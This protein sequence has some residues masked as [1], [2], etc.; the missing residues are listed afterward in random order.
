MSPAFHFD[1]LKELMPLMI[2]KTGE[3][4]DKLPND[5]VFDARP[6]LSKFTIDVLGVQGSKLYECLTNCY[7]PKD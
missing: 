1:F 3:L 2:S 7:V 6:W 4:I 5:E